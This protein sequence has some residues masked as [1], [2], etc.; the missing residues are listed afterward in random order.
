MKHRL[1]LLCLPLFLAPLS[2]FAVES[3]NPVPAT[4]EPTAHQK[5]YYFEHRMLPQWTHQ[6]QG[7]FYTDLS[8][9]RVERLR[10]IAEKIGGAMFAEKLSAEH[11]TAP[12]GVLLGFAAPSETT[13]CYFVFVAKLG[14][15]YRYFTFEKTEDLLGEGLVACIGEWGEDGGHRNFGFSKEASREAFLKAVTGLLN[16]PDIAPGAMMQLPSSGEK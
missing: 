6:S 1:W 11:Q 2:L 15:H 10:G 5:R 8:A 14:E 4:E 13:E 3:T 7:A 9:G 16:D 12:E